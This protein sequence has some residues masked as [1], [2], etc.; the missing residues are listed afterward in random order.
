[1]LFRSAIDRAGPDDAATVL[2]LLHELAEHED[3][4]RAVRS[5]TEDWRTALADPSVTVLLAHDGHR[6]VGYVSGVCQRNLWLG[7]DLFAMDDLYV[8][9]GARDQGVGRRLML[10]LAEHCQPDE[11]VITWGARSDNEAGH[12]FYRRLGA[13]LWPKV[14][15]SWS[16]PQYAAHLATRE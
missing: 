15:A 10:A 8:R 9:P 2:E 5:N 13:T 16:P 4:L 1:M 14:A 6:P 3:S 12:R 11:L 7:R